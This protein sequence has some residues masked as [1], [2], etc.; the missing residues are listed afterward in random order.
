M[1]QLNRCII[2]RD[3]KARGRVPA[4]GLYFILLVNARTYFTFTEI[5][6]KSF[7]RPALQ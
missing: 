3:K 2:K 5:P 7:T 1:V 4:R 6:E